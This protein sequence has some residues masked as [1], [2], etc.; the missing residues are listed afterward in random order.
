M[1]VAGM[2]KRVHDKLDYYGIAG[3]A[4]TGVC[5]I[6]KISFDEALPGEFS[7]REHRVNLYVREDGG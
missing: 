6:A 2:T 7:S 5:G 1:N 3:V 4:G